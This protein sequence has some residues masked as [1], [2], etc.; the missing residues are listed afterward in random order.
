M[1]FLV[2]SGVMLSA[3]TVAVVVY[4]ACIMML[5]S[6]LTLFNRKGEASKPLKIGIWGLTSLFQA[7]FWGFWA[8]FCVVLTIKFARGSLATPDW[9]YWFTGFLGCILLIGV[10]EYKY[11]QSSRSIEGIRYLQNRS[12]FFPLLAVVLFAVFAVD[13]SPNQYYGYELASRPL[14]F[15]SAGH[16]SERNEGNFYASWQH[17]ERLS[18]SS[19]IQV[20]D[21]TWRR[22]WQWGR[23]YYRLIGSDSPM[24][25]T[26]IHSSTHS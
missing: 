17:M 4:Y 1:S 7:C 12:I 20:P 6:P 18:Q 5:L 26:N 10:L 3:V 8:A 22:A 14:L 25:W 21:Q 2:F 19:Q 13:P 15:D 9:L 24:Q 23:M 11:A 16:G